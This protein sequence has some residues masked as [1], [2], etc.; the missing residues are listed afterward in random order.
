MSSNSVVYEMHDSE[1]PLASMGNEAT[2]EKRN[3]GYLKCVVLDHRPTHHN[4]SY[5]RID[6]QI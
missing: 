6:I 2:V 5:H 4:C 3:F 1:Y